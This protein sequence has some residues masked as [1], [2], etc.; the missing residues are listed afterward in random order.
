MNKEPKASNINND[1]IIY[2]LDEIK[3]EI[4]DIKRQY[5]TKEESLAL[6][7]EILSLREE[8][9]ALQKNRNLIGW[10]YPTLSA[11]FSAVFTYLIIQ[12]FT[13]NQ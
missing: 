11:A 8:V 4:V 3:S 13:S 10:L 1:L 12:Y 7:Q 5:V 6:K 2:R 9:H